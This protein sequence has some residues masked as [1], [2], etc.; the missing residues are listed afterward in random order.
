M[1]ARFGSAFFAR[2]V[3]VVARDLIGATFLVDGVG[4]VVV[5]TEAYAPDDPA[6]HSYRGRTSRNATMF[7]P[8]G[9][10]YAYRSYG[11]HWCANVVC[12][13]DGI[14]AAVLLRALEPVYGVAA[15]RD[16]R[17]LDDIALLCSG[18]GRLC[19]A[20]GISGEHD[21]HP[22]DRLPL[23]LHPPD[24]LQQIVCGQRVGITRASERP[25]RYAVRN[26]AFV[27]RPRPRA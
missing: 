24:S 19:Q 22:L 5:E 6:S 13:D 23:Q 16:R 12:G 14:G 27:S 17:G 20:L 15:M 11:I 7:G 21:G 8:P 2:D 26:S 1:T 9:H 10:L 4:G 25:W 18:P 3:L